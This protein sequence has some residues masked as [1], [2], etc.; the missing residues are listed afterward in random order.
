LV[1]AAIDPDYKAACD[2]AAERELAWNQDYYA[3]PQAIQTNKLTVAICWT[4][5]DF[6]DAQFASL[7]A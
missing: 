7:L 5:G 4:C 3:A 1:R 2:R 6:A